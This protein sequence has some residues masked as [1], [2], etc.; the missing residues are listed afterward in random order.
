MDFFGFCKS[1]VELESSSSS[2]LDMEEENSE[3][4][5][6]TQQQQRTEANAWRHGIAEAM[7]ADSPQ[8]DA[9]EENE[10]DRE[11]AEFDV[12]LQGWILVIISD[13]VSDLVLTSYFTAAYLWKGIYH[14]FHDNMAARAMQ[15]EQRFRTTTKGTKSWRIIVKH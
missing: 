3:I 9:N 7:W 8:N 15:L 4:L 2:Y 11:W 1:V 10:E 6:Q 13:E 5:S 12:L 14:F